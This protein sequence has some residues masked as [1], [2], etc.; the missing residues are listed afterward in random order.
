MSADLRALILKVAGDRLILLFRD[1]A[2]ELE[3]KPLEFG[4]PYV[5]RG[6]PPAR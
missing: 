2:T 1:A 3:R 5:V 6:P 4:S